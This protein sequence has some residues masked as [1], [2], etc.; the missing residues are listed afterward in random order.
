MTF[1]TGDTHG[2]TDVEKFY[3]RK[4]PQQKNLTKKDNVIILGDWGAI[5]DAQT[6]KQEKSLLNFY[7]DRK[8][9]TLIVAGN[10]DNH[11]RLNS[12][13]FPEVNMFNDT[14]KQ[15]SDS[16][17]LLQTGHIYII[18]GE[19]YFVFGGAES[20]D[21]EQRKAFISWW[22][23]EIPS[24][25]TMM[26]S[27]D[28][29]AKIKKVDYILTHATHTRM[30]DYMGYNDKK[31]TDPMLKFFDAVKDTVTYSF[32]F[33]GHYHKEMFYNPD[34]TLCLYNQIVSIGDVNRM[35]GD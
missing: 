17:F 3:M 13:E 4:F 29:L 24:T 21:K 19:T 22:P 35:L 27:L 20:I 1:L 16:I 33:H 6:S 34:K 31:E 26:E 2:R 28:L 10:H 30:Y 9:T 23:D 15:I 7:N 5:W 14:V 8:F 18:N 11:T 32:W 25:K 12:D